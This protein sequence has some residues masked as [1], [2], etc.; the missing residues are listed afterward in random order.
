MTL[1]QNL[2]PHQLAL[3]EEYRSG[4]APQVVELN[5]PVGAGKSY[6]LAVIAAERA[7][8]G[9]LV[10]VVLPHMALVA[11]WTQLLDQI[12]IS[13]T[14]VYANTAD[15]RLALDKGALLWP[16]PGLVVCTSSVIKSPLAAKT[17]VNTSPS[18][19]VVDDVAAPGSSE[20]G[21]SLRALAT[22]AHQ[23]IFTGR[24]ANALFPAS[25]MR[26]WTFPLVDREGQPVAPEF[27][28]RVHEYP[29]NLAEAELVR[30]AIEFFGQLPSIIPNLFLTRTA[31]QS[32]LLNGVQKLENPELSSRQETDQEPEAEL[33][34]FEAP[35][36]PEAPD[37]RMIDAIWKLLDEFDDLPPDGR[38]LA[39]IEEARSAFGQ[40]RPVVIVTGLVQEVDYL[41]AAIDS[42]GL[43][44]ST[45]TAGMRTE[46][47]LSAAE[48]LR[49]DNILVV[50]SAFFTD[51]L[52]PLPDGTR[53]IW[54]NPPKTRRQA[55]QRLGLGMS[56][57]GVEIVLLRA[58]P[59][60]TP[61]DELVERLEV[62]LQNPWQESELREELT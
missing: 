56:S 2:L 7:A 43:P 53:N 30:K 34:L 3:V 12:G 27:S 33:A 57:H 35:D 28:V 1:V 41:A 22:R 61:A 42:H 44:V 46:E 52:R 36:R 50:T 20:V 49:T 60:V 19:L 8:A 45:V 10:I 32:A 5:A 23:L 39:A 51:M 62:I 25:D 38:L 11:Q 14:A 17:L 13:P 31:I 4:S 6:T 58:V 21:R 54:F 48:N 9:V 47:R 29:G 15:F 37:R 55:Q 26:R 18:L 16:D 24:R 40:R 59:P